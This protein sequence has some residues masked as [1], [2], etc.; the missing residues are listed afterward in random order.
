MEN[1]FVLDLI[2]KKDNSNGIKTLS[3]EKI[4]Q[5]KKKSL[6]ENAQVRGVKYALKVTNT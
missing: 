4:S 6:T 2:D 1:N 5:V 3:L